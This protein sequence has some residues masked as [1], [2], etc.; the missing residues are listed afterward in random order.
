MD[1]IE[2]ASQCPILK[3]VSPDLLLSLFE[4][5][6]FQV[7]SF[8]RDE[9]LAMQGEEVNRLMILLKGSARGEMTD[10]LGHIIKIE[11][12]AAPKPLAGAFLFGH[13]NRFPV[14]VV[15]NESVKVLVIYRSEFLKLLRMN[16]T[17]QMNYLNLVGSKAQFLSKKIKFLSFKTIKGKIAHY[18]ISLGQD[19]DDY[20][21]IPASQQELADLFG[22]ARPSVARALGELEDEGMISAQCRRVKI[23]NKP[24]LMKYLNE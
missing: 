12:V 24:G 14:D 17:I 21:K 9:V 3:G 1:W 8:D 2:N 16:E 5:L 11:D 7:K 15:A 22:V 18:L 6:Q 20:M 23:L 10:F 13:E 19:N 4:K